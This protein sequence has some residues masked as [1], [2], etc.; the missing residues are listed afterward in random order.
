MLIVLTFKTR[1]ITK[2]V[3]TSMYYSSQKSAV[4]VPRSCKKIYLALAKRV[5]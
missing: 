3:L 4:R 1:E 2:L 5:A